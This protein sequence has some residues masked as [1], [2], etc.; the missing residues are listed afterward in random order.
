[1]TI[2]PPIYF[3]SRQSSPASSRRSSRTS[4]PVLEKLQ[5]QLELG[6]APSTLVPKKRALL[7]G[8]ALL[9]SL[10]LLMGG[11]EVGRQTINAKH[12]KNALLADI[13]N[14]NLIHDARLYDLETLRTAQC[15]NEQEQAKLQAALEACQPSKTARHHLPNLRPESACDKPVPKEGFGA[16]S[17]S[18][19]KIDFSQALS[20]L[21]NDALSEQKKN[22]KLRNSQLLQ[23]SAH[24]RLGAQEKTNKLRDT[25]FALKACQDS[26]KS[27]AVETA[28]GFAPPEPPMP[29]HHSFS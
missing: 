28:N 12:E 29:V 26:K 5:D 22:R 18:G 24:E 3:S 7:K 16:T 8:A 19:Q 14:L 10:A 15:V 23:R 9:G 17:V 11:G 1:M 25:Q 20:S 21:S 6:G 27:T 13:N 2:T 4:S